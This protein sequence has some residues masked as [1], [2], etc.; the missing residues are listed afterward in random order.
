[1]A[2][3]AAGQQQDMTKTVRVTVGESTSTSVRLLSLPRD[4]RLA[5]VVKGEAPLWALVLDEANFKRFPNGATAL[6]TARV[7]NA[8]SFGVQVPAEGTYFLLLDNRENAAP[9]RL[10]LRFRATLPPGVKA[11][12]G[13]PGTTGDPKSPVE[14]RPKI[15]QF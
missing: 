14:P 11:P 5:F 4:T 2:G 6:L 7:A 10:E 15:Q 9:N 13:E 8:A 1:M 12:A 3:P